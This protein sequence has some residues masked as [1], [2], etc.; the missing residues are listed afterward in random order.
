MGGL[1]C[2][3]V[4]VVFLGDQQEVVLEFMSPICFQ[5]ECIAR[6]VRG[7]PIWSFLRGSAL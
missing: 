4:E 2:N 3:F 6:G 1:I 7:R 5:N